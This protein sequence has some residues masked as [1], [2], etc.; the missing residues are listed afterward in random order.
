MA[1]EEGSFNKLGLILLLFYVTAHRH[2]IFS[3]ST[4]IDTL[5]YFIDIVITMFIN[6]HFRGWLTNEAK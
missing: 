3:E 4:N 2:N 5:C 1:T 6:V